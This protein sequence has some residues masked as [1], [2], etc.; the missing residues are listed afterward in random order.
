[1]VEAKDAYSE[2]QRYVELAQSK[3]SR[4]IKVW[5]MDD[6]FNFSHVKPIV[7]RLSK[8]TSLCIEAEGSSLIK[9][10]I[11]ITW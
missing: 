4:R 10:H 3:G 9:T 2:I 6:Y 1:M 5:F 8:L 7:D 11:C